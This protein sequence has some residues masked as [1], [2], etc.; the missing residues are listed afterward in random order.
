MSHHKYLASILASLSILCAAGCA[1]TVPEETDTESGSKGGNDTGNTNIDSEGRDVC[2]GDECKAEEEFLKTGQCPSATYVA[3]DGKTRKYC[4]NDPDSDTFDFILTEECED[5]CENGECKLFSGNSCST[6]YNVK[7]GTLT[8]GS[9]NSGSK[10]S[11]IP[12]CNGTLTDI[13]GVFKI[14]ISELGFYKFSVLSGSTSNWGNMLALECPPKTVITDN[15]GVEGTS[16][17]FVTMLPKG[18]YYLNIAPSRIFAPHFDAS[19]K[20][21]KIDYESSICGN[22]AGTFELIDL[23]APFE[24]TDSTSTGNSSENWDETKGCSGTGH[25]GKEKAYIFSL[26]KTT[27]I[28]ATVEITS[29]ELPNKAAIYI[30]KCQEGTRVTTRNCAETNSDTT[31][32]TAKLDA[33]EYVLFVDSDGKEFDYKLTITTN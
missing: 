17:S 14:D 3:C 32:K 18:S 28:T 7:L 26:S 29:D 22:Y 19:V 5:F 1:S 33:G 10:Y 31:I 24:K 9:T 25:G 15:C 30:T 23:T 6:P 27:N 16:D 11:S 13:M 2:K 12:A 21:D 20:V 8:T 4:D